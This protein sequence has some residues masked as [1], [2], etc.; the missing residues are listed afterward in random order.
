MANQVSNPVASFIPF[1]SFGPRVKTQSL[2]RP[3]ST[4][5]I[6]LGQEGWQAATL[7]QQMVADAYSSRAQT[8]IQFFVIARRP[9]TAIR[10]VRLMRQNCLLIGH[11]PLSWADV[12]LRYAPAGVDHWWPKR[13]AAAAEVD[14]FLTRCYGRLLLFQDPVGVHQ[15]LGKRT[16]ELI[17]S[18]KNGQRLVILLGS[19]AEA[20]SS[21][22]LFDV[23]Q[24][25]RLQLKDAPSTLITVQTTSTTETDEAARDLA[26]ANVYASLKEL[27]ALMINPAN[28]KLGISLAERTKNL[29]DLRETRLFDQVLITGGEETPSEYPP[30]A[31]IAEMAF[32]WM[33]IQ[34]TNP[35]SP[36]HAPLPALK[37][38]RTRSER[39][40]GYTFFNVSKLV[41]PVGA[42]TDI[43]AV[44]L[45]N[46]L[47]AGMRRRSAT[48]EVDEQIAALIDLCSKEMAVDN[49]TLVRER[50]D[51]L[52]QRVSAD[53]LMRE[54][55]PRQD[56]AKPLQTM[57]EA[58]I[59]VLNQETKVD[60]V[61]D[62]T[63]ENPALKQTTLHTRIMRAAEAASRE[64]INQ[65]NEW[66]T[67][68]TCLQ[69][70]S[71]RAAL[72][73]IVEVRGRL[74][75][76]LSDYRL[77]IESAK[78]ELED[79]RRVLRTQS[80]DYDDRFSGMK[81]M[82]RG[83]PSK[84]LDDL[85][86]TFQ[87]MN[88]IALNYIYLTSTVAAWEALW[89]AVST[90][91][92]NVRVALQQTDRTEQSINGYLADVQNM[93]RDASEQLPTP[94]PGHMLLDTTWF[95]EG[96]APISGVIAAPAE[97]LMPRVYKAWAHGKPAQEQQIFQFLKE[98]VPACSRFLI[99]SVQF[100]PLQ[101]YMLQRLDEALMHTVNVMQQAAEPAWMPDPLNG[102]AWTAFEWIRSD[103]DAA[104]RVLSLVP[105]T[106][107]WR[108]REVISPDPDELC[109]FRIIQGVTAES[110]KTL[111]EQYRRIYDRVTA[112]GIPLHLDRLWENRLPD[113]MQSSLQR[114]ASMFWERAFQAVRHNPATAQKPLYDLIH[115]FGQALHVE[116]TG[117]QRVPVSADDFTMVIYSLKNLRLRLPPSE[118]PVVFS[119]SNR[120]ARDLA[121][122][123]IE[124]ANH[125]TSNQSFV[126]IVNVNNQDTMGFVTDALQNEKFNVVVLDEARFKDVVGAKAAMN[127]LNEIILADVDL[128]KVSPFM[129]NGPVPDSMF[130]GREQEIKDV[131]HT[132]GTHSVAL[133]G[134]RRIGKTSILQ[135]VHR[136]L[137][138]KGSNYKAYYMD[139]GN[140]ST[141]DKF[142]SSIK[143]R[144]KAQSPASDPT[145]FENIVHELRERHSE[146]IVFLLDE[147]DRLIACDQERP[148]QHFELLLRTFRALSNEGDC[149]FIF[150]GEQLLAQTREDAHSAMF[151]FAIPVRL[152]LLERAA[153]DRLVTE[154][155]EL[156]NILFDN[157]PNLTKRIYEIS[158]GHPSIVQMICERLID[159][160]NRDGS[161]LIME[162]HLIQV[163]KDSDLQKEIITTFWG[164]MN[165][166]ARLI[167]L[168]WPPDCPHL[169]VEEIQNRLTPILR[170][171]LKIS[172]V[173]DAIR[174]LDLY[175][176]IDL[177]GQDCR[178]VPLDFPTQISSMGMRDLEIR[179]IL[180]DMQTP[181]RRK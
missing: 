47:L 131:R 124:A 24:L 92:D 42:A 61:S 65:L 68:W 155:F 134:G 54:V 91:R 7:L 156:M 70:G 136:L 181:D 36:T 166:L 172:E 82:I 125:A 8:A 3:V 49:Q 97:K 63:P 5:V 74:N 137:E 64:L 146:Q 35:T 93:L 43:A 15:E 177:K 34:N 120:T 138:M 173:R 104:H 168:I 88:E 51:L 83:Q 175:H 170:R 25:I 105:E 132:I 106:F 23:A 150:S 73:V 163:L 87:K 33:Q 154:P 80:K 86:V 171:S 4:L 79:A 145:D 158:A 29:G 165:G 180:E 39:F 113:L 77:N 126:I 151:N 112:E 21:G 107:A 2:E 102:S 78:R 69:G 111:C 128:T 100:T 133:I 19:L 121:Q 148:N 103:A 116:P 162:S 60:E 9:T 32:T 141:Y 96:I 123:I 31:A 58:L 129:A 76:T 44:E 28:Y 16:A 152:E 56:Q 10:K 178:L 122:D 37:P 11:E 167:T 1:G 160:L 26:M 22:L 46:K 110:I 174:D 115:F 169:S 27:D 17:Q 62:T 52:I 14:P 20:E 179:T 45:A 135:K 50:L 67:R 153:V 114:Q 164:Q 85:F 99:A 176:F 71:L 6:G 30:T 139:C 119:Y 109:L 66:P 55:K 75:T 142:F 94:V 159:A 130:F 53:A 72:E 117:I 90:L 38:P 149:R 118:C 18:S 81:R 98:I 144:W 89:N 48:P 140:I 59:I 157:A 101:K 84:L 40:D 12:P 95:N 13:R 108:Q 143:R 41:L 127:T 57:A 161:R 147:V